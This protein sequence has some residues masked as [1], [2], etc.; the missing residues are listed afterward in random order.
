MKDGPANKVV[1]NIFRKNNL[2]LTDDAKIIQKNDDIWE[3]RNRSRIFQIKDNG[4]YLEIN[5]LK[6]GGQN[7]PLKCIRENGIPFT[8]LV[9]NSYRKGKITYNDVA[10]YLK[11]RTKHIPKVEQ[12]VRG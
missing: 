10:D 7:I 3:I 6:K 1:I 4:M 8:S 9:F 2:I 11:I 12:L 5:E